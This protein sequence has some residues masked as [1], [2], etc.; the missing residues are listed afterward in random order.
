M[1]LSVFAYFE[2]GSIIFK[3]PRVPLLFLQICNFGYS[4]QISRSF[5]FKYDLIASFRLI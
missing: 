2:L 4:R 5:D 3:C 1:R